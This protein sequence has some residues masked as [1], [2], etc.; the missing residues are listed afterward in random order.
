VLVAYPDYF[1]I[2]AAAA[3]ARTSLS[4]KTVDANVSQ[5]FRKLDL[6]ESPRDHRRVLAVLAFL[7]AS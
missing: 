5:I 7:R 2:P 3:R 6:H 1:P 4:R